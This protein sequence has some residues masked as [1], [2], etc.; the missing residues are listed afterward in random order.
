M[1]R[2]LLSFVVCSA[3][4]LGLAGCASSN[5]DEAQSRDAF[6][7]HWDLVQIDSGNDTVEQEDLDRLRSQGLDV[8]LVLT[9]D[10]AATLSLF[11][12]ITE[13]S[14]T[15]KNKTEA[16]LSLDNG[17]TITMTISDD[18]LSMGQNGQALHFEQR[19]VAESDSSNSFSSDA[20]AISIDP[21]TVADNDLVSIVIESKAGDRLGDV[22]INVV[23]T[24][25]TDE[26][27]RIAADPE[28][29]SV[30]DKMVEM[31][32]GQVIQPGKFADVYFWFD[33]EE[34]GTSNPEMLTSV[35]GAFVITNSA[36]TQV[37]GTYPF[38]L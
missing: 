3:L 1:K 20:E 33:H 24:N 22:G 8:Y 6:S 9:E 27:L 35:E 19:A 13:G 26:P 28:S 16:S 15:P 31:L 37:L 34:I 25:K 18:V 5:N 2:I 32:G 23:V 29:V 38:S 4:V 17:E 21:L 12:G 14:W 11:D 10:G 7:G 36:G 30:E